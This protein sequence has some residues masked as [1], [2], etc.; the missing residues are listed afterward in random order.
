MKNYFHLPLLLATLKPSTL[1]I[2]SS[3]S[4]VSNN[5]WQRSM[6]VNC[7]LLASSFQLMLLL[8]MHNQQRSINLPLISRNNT[9][10]RAAMTDVLFCL[11]LQACDINTPSFKSTLLYVI[12]SR[13]NFHMSFTFS[14]SD[15]LRRR[16]F[17]QA[18]SCRSAMLAAWSHAIALL[19]TSGSNYT[20]TGE[21]LELHG[22]KQSTSRTTLRVFI[23]RPR[24][25]S[26]STTQLQMKLKTCLKTFY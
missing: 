17:I 3:S 12:I 23:C 2:L 15:P 26:E 13:A 25:Q 14:S 7:W 4:S 19:L 24:A 21:H 5:S 22:P 16:E 10:N 11:L 1:P 18:L 9:Q 8:P 20:C 6:L